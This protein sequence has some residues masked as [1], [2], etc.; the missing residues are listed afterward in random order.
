[1]FS[2]LSL[3]SE[4][5][6]SF[7]GR[8]PSE[9]NHWANNLFRLGH[10]H[11]T[12]HTHLGGLCECSKCT[13]L[14]VHAP[15]CSFY[16]SLD[17][18]LNDTCE[19]LHHCCCLPGKSWP[20][21]APLFFVLSRPTLFRSRT[22]ELDVWQTFSSSSLTW[23]AQIINK[24]SVI[25]ASFV[26]VMDKWRFWSIFGFFKNET[27]KSS[28]S[29]FQNRERESF[30]YTMHSRRGRVKDAVLPMLDWNLQ[31]SAQLVLP[32]CS[33]WKSTEYLAWIPVKKSR[34]KKDQL[35]LA[36]LFLAAKKTKKM[37][38]THKL[39]RKSSG[40]KNWVTGQGNSCDVRKSKAQET[41]CISVL[42]L[43]RR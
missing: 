2:S 19:L 33:I 24:A 31:C 41:K 32:C 30:R 21:I 4:L 13:Y 39:G 8:Q 27:L 40:L 5:T 20:A 3:V 18:P 1:M 26:F 6:E 14:T 11:Y 43:F 35:Q 36:S 34:L 25:T 23:S 12:T 29:D 37:K 15:K 28:K 17:L 10:H 38:R 7:V 9:L 42:A 16:F 22:Q